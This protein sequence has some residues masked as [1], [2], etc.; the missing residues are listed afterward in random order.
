MPAPRPTSLEGLGIRNFDVD[1]ALQQLL[2][3]GIPPD[4][5]QNPAFLALPVPHLVPAAAFH[6]VNEERPPQDQQHYEPPVRA[7]GS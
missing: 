2:E 3:R 5:G 7:G 1:Q 6:V 4:F